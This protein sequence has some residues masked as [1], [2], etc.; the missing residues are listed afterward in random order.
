MRE[1]GSA[2]RCSRPG[3]CEGSRVGEWVSTGWS[4]WLVTFAGEILWPLSGWMDGNWSGGE[5]LDP[6]GFAFTVLNPIQLYGPRG[7]REGEWVTTPG[8]CFE[9][10]GEGD[11]VDMRGGG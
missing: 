2:A 4:H 5:A 6:Q 1:E 11:V 7:S 8:M 10:K 9:G 3:T